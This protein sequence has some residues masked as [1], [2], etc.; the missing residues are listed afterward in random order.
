ML[1]IDAVFLDHH[2][3]SGRATIR[4]LL[5]K[6]LHDIVHYKRVVVTQTSRSLRTMELGDRVLVNLFYHF[7]RGTV[8]VGLNN[9]IITTNVDVVEA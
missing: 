8:R 7:K 6:R 5:W 2:R 1:D 4:A 9:E 3:N